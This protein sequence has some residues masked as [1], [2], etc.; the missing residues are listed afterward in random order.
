MPLLF[1]KKEGRRFGINT[2]YLF[3]DKLLLSSVNLIVWLSVM[4]YL[5]P[6]HSGIMNYSLSVVFLFSIL[7]DFGMETVIVREIVREEQKQEL[8]MGSCFVFRL[9]V[10]GLV[11]LLIAFITYNQEKII[12]DFIMVISLRFLFRAFR[13]IDYYFQA[14]VIS[15]YVV[16]ARAISLSFVV[17]ACGLAFF[18]RMPL[19]AFAWVLLIESVILHIC[20]AILYR[21]ISNINL[22]AWQCSWKCIRGFIKDCM[23]LLISGAAIS[24]YMRIDQIMIKEF[25]GLT[26]V[27]YF[28]A[29]VR[30]SEVVYAIPI[31]IAGSLFP[32]I[33]KAKEKGKNIY[34]VNL[35]FI[36]CLTFW[37]SIASSLTVMLFSPFWVNLLLGKEFAPAVN[38]IFLYIWSSVFVF[39]GVV[40]SKWAVVENF[41]RYIMW[42]TILGA[43]LNVVL[44]LILIPFL[45]I[46]GAALAT[47][48]SQAIAAVFS[49]LLHP[50]TRPIF[51]LQ[52]KSINFFYVLKNIFLLKKL[53]EEPFRLKTE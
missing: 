3:I 17:I 21:K 49:S 14:N 33:V 47:I 9:L 25:L 35:E 26:E 40:R 48:V 28:S 5:G 20:L 32:A 16:Y 36:F 37:L 34:Y 53:H 10:S 7:A 4:R 15:K 52:L 6:E 39:W 24:I 38:I 46:Q 29:A 27:G 50:K 31:V 51:F 44:N 42:Y 43:I 18:F 45:G 13:N 41:Q 23:P 11:I 30:I 1:N 22:A 19:I 8:L 2:F 12:R